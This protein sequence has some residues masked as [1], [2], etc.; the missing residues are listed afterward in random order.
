MP[1]KVY[2]VSKLINKISYIVYETSIREY[3]VKWP[4][5][6]LMRIYYVSVSPYQYYVYCKSC[7]SVEPG[8]LRVRCKS[9]QDSGI[10]LNKV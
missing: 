6:Y 9:C 4:A 10:V 2:K 5:I 3:I 1:Y 8:K 7:D